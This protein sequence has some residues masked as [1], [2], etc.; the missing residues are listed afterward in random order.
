MNTFCLCAEISSSP[1]FPV[2]VTFPL[3]CVVS[4]KPLEDTLSVVSTDNCGCSLVIQWCQTSSLNIPL[5]L[6]NHY[7]PVHGL[8]GVGSVCC[9]L[10]FIF[11]HLSPWVIKRVTG[12][13]ESISQETHMQQLMRATPYKH[14]YTYIHTH[15][16]AR[17]QW[18]SDAWDRCIVHLAT[19]L[20][21]NGSDTKGAK[22]RDTKSGGV[23]VGVTAS[24][25]CCC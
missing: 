11:Q 12:M 24:F 7:Q 14:K 15:A 22:E 18:A 5:L 1:Q 23:V 4:I 17:T 2:C 21:Q 9:T 10:I 6:L 13:D 8:T 19:G 25:I 3:Y 20:R 16:S